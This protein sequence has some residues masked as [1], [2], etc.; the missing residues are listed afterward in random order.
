VLAASPQED[1]ATIDGILTFG[2][3]WLPHTRDRARRYLIDG[4]RL[5]LPR[6][7]SSVLAHRMSALA[8]PQ[9][10]ELYE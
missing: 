10:T 4:L 8:S 9:E 6:G 5:F 7:S 1:A 3:S 2:L